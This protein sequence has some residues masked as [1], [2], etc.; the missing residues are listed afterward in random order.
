[1]AAS[2]ETNKTFIFSDSRNPE[3]SGR[4]ADKSGRKVRFARIELKK[5]I[6]KQEHNSLFSHFLFLRDI[7]PEL[8]LV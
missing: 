3:D 4:G 2:R 6:A 8:E 5:K 1:L 7:M